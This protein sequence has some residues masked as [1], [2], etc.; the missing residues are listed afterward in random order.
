MVN[1]TF[2]GECR[3]RIM[4]LLSFKL[5]T[6]AAGERWSQCGV[7]LIW[8]Q[9]SHIYMRCLVA[10]Q[11]LLMRSI[12]ATQGTRQVIRAATESS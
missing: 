11:T 10:K 2:V 3:L 1:F 5:L 12:C 9:V 7:W 6:F 8:Q 4:N